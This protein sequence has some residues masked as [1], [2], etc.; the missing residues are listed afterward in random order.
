MVGELFLDFSKTAVPRLIP[1]LCYHS[2][3][4]LEQR[5]ADLVSDSDISSNGKHTCSQLGLK[6]PPRSSSSFI[7]S[8]IGHRDT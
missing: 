4:L 8:V 6:Y 7:Y 2:S 3:V 5:I 1:S